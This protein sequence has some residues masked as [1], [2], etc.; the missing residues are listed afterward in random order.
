MVRK[1]RG[2]QPVKVTGAGI[3]YVKNSPDDIEVDPPQ[4]TKKATPRQI[5]KQLGAAEKFHRLKKKS[6]VIAADFSVSKS[7]TNVGHFSIAI[8][9][10][11]GSKPNPGYLSCLHALIRGVTIANGKILNLRHQPR[12][13]HKKIV[14]GRELSIDF[15]IVVTSESEIQS[16]INQITRPNATVS[17]IKRKSITE[18]IVM[19]IDFPQNFQMEDFLEQIIPHD[20]ILRKELI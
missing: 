19:E 1:G 12:S 8:E 5:A 9:S 11:R 4:S 17:N 6:G 3:G 20:G 13:L 14:T 2:F 7:T 10:M 16:L 18:R 15:P